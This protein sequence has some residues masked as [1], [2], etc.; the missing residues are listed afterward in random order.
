MTDHC[1]VYHMLLSIYFNALSNLREAV[2][3]SVLDTIKNV[4]VRRY[5][6]VLSLAHEELVWIL[7]RPHRI[8]HL[9]LCHLLRYL[10]RG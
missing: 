10:A 2:E 8:T 1:I 4:V 5:L 9:S 7:L 6:Q 3:K